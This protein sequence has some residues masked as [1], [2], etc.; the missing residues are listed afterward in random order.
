MPVSL[1]FGCLKQED[2]KF[3]AY[4]WVKLCHKTKPKEVSIGKGPE[5]EVVDCL[6][7]EKG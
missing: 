6:G 7:N 5:R 3:D 2:C 1:S 4:P